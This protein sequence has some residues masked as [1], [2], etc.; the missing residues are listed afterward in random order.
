M[1]ITHTIITLI[2]VIASSDF[3]SFLSSLGHVMH[4]YVSF[5]ALHQ[6]YMCAAVIAGLNGN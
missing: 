6:P 1:G 3:L 5:P 4:S 2:H